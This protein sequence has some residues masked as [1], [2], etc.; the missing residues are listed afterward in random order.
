LA[1][2]SKI[3][4]KIEE[5]EFGYSRN[6]MLMRLFLLVCSNL[7][8]LTSTKTNSETAPFFFP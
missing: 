3:K 4:E 5:F 2:L 1:G 6:E 7:F 8:S